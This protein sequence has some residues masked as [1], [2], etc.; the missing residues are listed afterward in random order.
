VIH[1]ELITVDGYRRFRHEARTE[2][3][4]T[5]PERAIQWAARIEGL[6]EI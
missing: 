3:E 4:R 6:I 1:R 5:A 2:G